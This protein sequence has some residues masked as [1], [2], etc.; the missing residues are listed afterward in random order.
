MD[1]YPV[2]RQTVLDT[3]DVRGLAEFYRQ[4]L[5]PDHRPVEESGDPDDPGWLVLD[6]PAG[7][8]RLAF[9]KVPELPRVTWPDGPV[10]Q[11]VHLDLSVPDREALDAQHE[12]V[13]GLGAELLLDRSGEAEPVRVY[14][15]PSG[16][17]FCVGVG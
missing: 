2:L 9:Q 3:T 13:L 4:L 5:G 8:S 14:A 11:Q 17:P 15:D 6:G 12:R 10:P 16:H 1:D 7:G